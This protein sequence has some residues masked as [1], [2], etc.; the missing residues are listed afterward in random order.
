M[1][2]KQEKVIR[3]A[4]VEDNQAARRNFSRMFSMS[5]EFQCVGAYPAG[6]LLFKSLP[7]INPDIVLM[8]INLPGLDGIECVSLLRAQYPAIQ[9]IMLTVFEDSDRIF[10]ALRAGA[11]GYLLKRILP[12]ELLQA[13]RYVHAGGAAMTS[14]VAR[15]VAEEFKQ[16]PPSGNP[17]NEMEQLSLREMEVLE[18]LAEGCLVKEIAAHMKVGFGTVRTY[19]RRIYEKLH[20]RSRAQA[21]AHYY[22]RQ[23]GN[24]TDATPPSITR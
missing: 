2:A 11:S 24:A 16:P 21:A 22:H 14:L 6:E 9:V 10:R 19:I 5:P 17:S 1:N 15:R 18:K 12:E 13:V 23:E 4:L 7:R 20:V 3:V 8:D